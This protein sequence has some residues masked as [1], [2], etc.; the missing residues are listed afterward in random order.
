[1]PL[2]ENMR[3]GYRQI[4]ERGLAVDA[5]NRAVG[6]LTGAQARLVGLKPGCRTRA[7]RRQG[8]GLAA[9]IE[10]GATVSAEA[11]PEAAA[12]HP[13]IAAMLERDQTIAALRTEQGQL[14]QQ[15]LDTE[16]TQRRQTGNRRRARQREAA[17]AGV[18]NARLLNRLREN[19]ERLASLTAQR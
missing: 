15:L 11:V 14:A 6:P 8:A 10:A 7:H 19:Q 17:M 3:E 12:A 9:R 4:M 13:V 5:E 2:S 18:E 1:M 16:R